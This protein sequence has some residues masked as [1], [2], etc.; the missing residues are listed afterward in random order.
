MIRP[1]L[2]R[3][4]L[5]GSIGMGK[6]TIADMFEAESVPVWDADE[7]VHRLYAQ[8]EP[9]KV[10]L[11]Q[12]FGDVLS[13]NVVDRV[14]LSAAL[15]GRFDQL[16]ALVHPATVADRKDFLQRHAAA[17][18]VV[19]D[20]PLLYETG[21]E[22]TLDKVLVVSAPAEIQADRVLKR[23]GMTAEKFAAILARQMPDAEKR[24]RADFVIDTSQTL[25]LC[26][27]EVRKI[28]ADLTRD[29]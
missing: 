20:I 17:P 25:D 8:S 1:G 4:G 14:K 9:L 3:L 5:T 10:A 15:H 21:A 27:E 2:V 23:P 11:T 26:R 13:D 29:S 24:R 7:A 6:S 16:N 28:I 19:A 12:A 18:L 22:A